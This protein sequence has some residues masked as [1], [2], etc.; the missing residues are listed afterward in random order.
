M[1]VLQRMLSSGEIS[2]PEEAEE[3]LTGEDERRT[4]ARV[5]DVGTLHYVGAMLS[6]MG[7]P[8]LT[9]PRGWPVACLDT[10]QSIPRVPSASAVR[11]FALGGRLADDALV[12][13]EL[14][15][16]LAG[17]TRDTLLDDEQEAV[18]L[19]WGCA[20]ALTLPERCVG[21]RSDSRPVWVMADADQ[22][23]VLA[24]VDP[25]HRA[26][27]MAAMR[28]AG[29]DPR[30]SIPGIVVQALL[31][32]R[33]RL[34]PDTYGACGLAFGIDAAG[35]TQGQIDRGRCWRRTVHRV[36]RQPDF[37]V[38]SQVCGGA[39]GSW[40]CAPCRDRLV[41]DWRSR[42]LRQV[43]DDVED[44]NDN[45]VLLIW[46]C[47]M[48]GWTTAAEAAMGMTASAIGPWRRGIERLRR[49]YPD[50]AYLR[51]VEWTRDGAGQPH[52]TLL[53]RS[54]LLMAGM[55]DEAGA[56]GR[57]ELREQVRATDADNKVRR[58]QG[59]KALP[60][61]H[62]RVGA[63]IAKIGLE[64]GYGPVCYVAPVYNIEGIVAE[65]IKARQVDGDMPVDLRRITTSGICGDGKVTTFFQTARAGVAPKGV[66]APVP[67]EPR[68]ALSRPGAILG[69]AR[70]DATDLDPMH[71][72]GGRR[73]GIH[74]DA[75]LLSCTIYRTPPA[76]VISALASAGDTSV[77]W[78][79]TSTALA[80]P[81]AGETVLR[82]TGATQV[83]HDRRGPTARLL[84]GRGTLH[85]LG[86]LGVQVA[87]QLQILAALPSQ[88]PP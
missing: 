42:A 25:A 13:T 83:P 67:V 38:H 79:V 3:W 60:M 30:R 46:T 11:L 22:E 81:D 18:S 50:L 68:D 65:V 49:K 41:A 27:A 74:R 16:S 71:Q 54:K 84:D 10:Q 78:H 51:V 52:V 39:C 24:L 62:T 66:K 33:L 80:T 29:Y 85:A 4:R 5:P 40:R 20:P 2:D 73:P 87:D 7:L 14:G 53:V 8:A 19:R 1:A 48:T 72:H 63:E 6:G 57:A 28:K 61:P 12:T 44:G 35:R 86:L 21:V 58:E 75:E 37:S 56:P 23:R 36:Y 64:S 70:D 77:G 47:D 31:R 82:V 76:D 45:Y 26:T 17:L 32:Q 55:M 9:L 88:K 15:A 69:K 59:R 43:Q 34:G